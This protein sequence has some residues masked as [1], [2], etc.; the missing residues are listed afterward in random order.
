MAA[1][2]DHL[3]RT[4]ARPMPRRRALRALGGTLVTAAVPGVLRAAPARAHN[5]VGTLTTA[6]NPSCRGEFPVKCVCPVPGGCYIGGCGAVGSTCCCQK[7]SDGKTAGAVACPP[8]TRC[9]RPGEQNCPC[10][11]TCGG[12]NVCCGAGEYCANPR[13]QL[14]CKQGER[15]CGRFCCRPNQ[16]CRSARVG[17]ASTRFCEDRCPPSQAW[18]G[19]N[20]CCPP[21]WYC[22][23]ERTGLCKRCRGDQ[24]E[25]GKKC[26]D[27]RTSRCCGKAGCCP[28]NR[29]CCVNGDKQVC[30]PPRTKCAIPI[31]PGNIGIV[32]RTEAICCPV[33]RLNNDPKVCCPPGQ[34][35]LNTPG[36]SIPPRGISPFCCP[37]G[38]ICPSATLGK[39]CVDLQGDPRNCGRCGNVCPSGICSGGVCA[40]Q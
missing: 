40:P 35:A 4:L 16:E 33:E 1:F 10:T 25:C 39:T 6:C 26:C 20:K 19:S 29:S 3:A 32:P 37:P 2:L 27:R 23:N 11:N 13:E 21:R 24:E 15:G 30:C 22:V 14:C 31:L 38:Q 36:M 8:G 12:P 34:V 9:G 18:C 17:T 7:G 5:A 28:K